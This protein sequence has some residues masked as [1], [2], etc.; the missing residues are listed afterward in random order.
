MCWMAINLEGE[1]EGSGVE[2]GDLD[3]PASE[4]RVLGIESTE[5]LN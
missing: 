4:W 2:V 5:V 1:Y 3:R